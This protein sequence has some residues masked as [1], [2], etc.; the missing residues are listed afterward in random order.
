MEPFRVSRTA[1]R[2]AVRRAAHQVLDRPRVFDDPFA[3]RII[4]EKRTTEVQRLESENPIATAARAFFAV[5]SRI[6]ED[7]LADAVERGVRQYVVLGAGLDTFAYRNPHE[8]RGLRVFEVDRP[9]TRDWKRHCLA[10]AAI[11]IPSSVTFAPVDFE[12]QMLADGLSAAGFDRA[13]PA[14]FS[15]L[16]VTMYLTLEAIDATLAFIGGLPAESGVAFDY[17]VPA[18]GLSVTERLVLAGMSARV[19]AGGEPFTSFFEPR[20]LAAHLNAAG[21]QIVEDLGREEINARYFS[22][23]TDGLMLR[24]RLGRVVIA[25]VA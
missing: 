2:V 6:A 10:R 18:S 25:R 17:G 11:A 14:F 7:A 19:S 15:W 4:G 24:G 21:L 20:D 8:A 16:G 13:A 12:H 22:G 5:R 1:F 3:L 23:R 9:A